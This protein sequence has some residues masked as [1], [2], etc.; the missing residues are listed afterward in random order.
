MSIYHIDRHYL[1]RKFC[2]FKKS[3]Y[4]RP[5]GEARLTARAQYTPPAIALDRIDQPTT[6]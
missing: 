6:L 5:T 3:S 1:L 2:L 4:P